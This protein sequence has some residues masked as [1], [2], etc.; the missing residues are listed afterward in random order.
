MIFDIPACEYDICYISACECD[1]TGSV[2]NT[3]CDHITGQCSCYPGVDT[4]TC[5]S[6]IPNYY[7]F[8]NTS[9]P[10]DIKMLHV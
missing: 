4:R 10:G 9:L 2:N 1:L 7:G 6:C 8:T 3:V 5:A